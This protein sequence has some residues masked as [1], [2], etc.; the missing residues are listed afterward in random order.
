M[1]GRSA[2]PP[3]RPGGDHVPG[4]HSYDST[5]ST[6]SSI[7]L[8]VH[9]EVGAELRLVGVAGRDDHP[10][11]PR[12]GERGAQVAMSV[13]DGYASVEVWEW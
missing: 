2:A 8:A 11:D 1:T 9:H 6:S 7:D 12:V 4:G 3:R 10:V 13:R 5:I